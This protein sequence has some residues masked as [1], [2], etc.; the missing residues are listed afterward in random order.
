[1]VSLIGPSRVNQIS[2]DGTRKISVDLWID[3]FFDLSCG[4]A[5]INKLQIFSSKDPLF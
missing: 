3:C 5:K 2:Q 4:N 1:M